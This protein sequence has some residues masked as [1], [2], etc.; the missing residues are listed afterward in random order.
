VCRSLRRLPEAHAWYRL[1]LSHDSL[2]SELQ[3]RLFELDAA[4]APEASERGQ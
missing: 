4:I 2:D 3:R 1:A